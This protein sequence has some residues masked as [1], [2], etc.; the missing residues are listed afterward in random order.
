M[1]S[2]MSRRPENPI[3]SPKSSPRGNRSP[4]VPRQ[5][6]TGTLKT[7]ISLGKTPVIVHSGPFYLMKEPP[8]ESELTGS[9]NLLLKNSLEHSYNKF[10]GR[11]VKDQLSAFLPN[12]PGNIDTP[13]HI[14]NSSLRALIDKPPIGGKELI[15]LTANQLLGFRLHAGPL[16]EQYRLMNQ[17]V[18]RK[19]H[20]HKK[21]KQRSGETPAYDSHSEISDVVQTHEKKHKKEKRR[22][23]KEERKKKKKDKKKKKQKHS[24]EGSSGLIGDTTPQHSSCALNGMQRNI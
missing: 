7:T 20:K 2:E 10:S 3:S 19:K 14:D 24:P 6:S 13:A 4:V 12:L 17:S 16:P 5:D 1:M 11:K 15:P 18:Q 9:A 23:E 22:E 21:N 8:A